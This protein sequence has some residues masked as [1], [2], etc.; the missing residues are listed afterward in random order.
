VFFAIDSAAARKNPPALL[1]G[2]DA[3]KRGMHIAGASGIVCLLL[4]V[5]CV[6][7]DPLLKR[8]WGIEHLPVGATLQILLAAAAYALASKHVHQ[9][10]RFTF[11]PVKEVGLLFAGIF[12]TMMPALAFLDQRAPSLG[13]T[14]PTQ[15]Y[16]ATGLLSAALDNA[17]TYLSFLQIATS[18]LGFDLTPADVHRLIDGSFVIVDAAGGRS[19]ISGQVMLEAISLGAVFFGAV[20]YIGNGPNFMVKAVAEGRGL[21]MPSFFGYLLFALAILGPILV[22]NWLVFIR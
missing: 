20:T 16:F 3:A 15:F 13:L 14:S 22:L 7:V 1:A 8:Q 6:F 17:P 10:N 18:V 9:V 4:I 19:D 5:A 12:A 2:S 11:G 21:K